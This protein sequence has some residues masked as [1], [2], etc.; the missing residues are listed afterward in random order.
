LF[1]QA[2]VFGG[3]VLEAGA[4]VLNFV[5]QEVDL[6]FLHPQLPLEELLAD[7]G[8]AAG[9]NEAAQDRDPCESV[10]DAPPARQTAG[11]WWSYCQPAAAV[12]VGM[13]SITSSI[14]R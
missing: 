9:G 5:L 6:V 11:L 14:S 10:H 3:H 12:R 7:V 8:L 13:C 4:L 2:A 1:F